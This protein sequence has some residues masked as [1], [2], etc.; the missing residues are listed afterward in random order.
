MSDWTGYAQK[1]EAKLGYVNT[2]YHEEPRL[3]ITA[4][5]ERQKGRYDFVISSEVFEHVPPPVS[6]AFDSLLELLRPGGFVVFTAPYVKASATVEH[7]PDLHEYEL[8]EK[9]GRRQLRNV[10]RDRR[11]QWFSNLVFH[12]G[13]GATLE[14]RLFAE[15][16]LL[17]HFAAAGFSDVRVR[18]EPE[19]AAGIVWSESWSLPVTARRPLDG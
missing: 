14:M 9:D 10:T 6:E 7:Y 12:G 17:A 13:D 18:S 4:V 2:F 15:S 8:L 1:L 3:D 19:E 16:D 11:I 5:D